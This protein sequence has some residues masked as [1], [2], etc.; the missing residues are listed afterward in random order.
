VFQKGTITMFTGIPFGQDNPYSY[1]EAKRVLGLAMDDLRPSEKLAK[2]FDI[3]K[4]SS[5]RSSITGKDG[6]RVW[7]FLKLNRAAESAN[8]TEFP[9]LTFAIHQTY[10]NAIITVPNGIRSEFRRKLV[11]GGLQSFREIFRSILTRFDQHLGH[12][13]GLIPYVEVLQ[14]HYRT[15]RSEPTIDGHLE[16]DLRTAFDV[17][18]LNCPVKNQPEWL[19]V[20]YEVLSNKSSNIQLGVGGKL[21]YDF[22]ISNTAEV[23]DVVTDV[24]IA[25]KPLVDRLLH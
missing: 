18:S 13:Q 10:S 22:P 11:Q 6:I 5:G 1:R 2:Q 21:Y 4:S 25:C 23:L 3:D 24:W 17:R 8:F 14:R 12:I 7:D 16:F 15:Q 19:N 9:H 20:A